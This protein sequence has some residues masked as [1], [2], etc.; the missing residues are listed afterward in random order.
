[1][2][3]CSMP[4]RH[5][6]L[7]RQVRVRRL[8]RGRAARARLRRRQDLPQRVRLAEGGVRGQDARR[9]AA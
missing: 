9:D 5:V 2:W 3:R 4:R 6:V 1:M 8:V 7:A